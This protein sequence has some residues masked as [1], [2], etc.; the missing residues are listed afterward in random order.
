MN[1]SGLIWK[2]GCIKS[3]SATGEVL[4]VAY[5]MEKSNSNKNDEN[6]NIL[7]SS[8]TEINRE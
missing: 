6:W 7:V 8:G 4:I 5:P 3:K 1:D 2:E